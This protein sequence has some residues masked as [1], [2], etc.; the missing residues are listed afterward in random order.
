MS[1][2]GHV[3]R[4]FYHRL[5]GR[6]SVKDHVNRGLKAGR[7]LHLQEGV[8]LDYSH[9]WHIELGDDVTIAPRAIILAHDAS[10]RRSLGYTRLGKVKI[11]NRVFIGAGSIVLPGVTIGDDVIV[12]AGSVVSSDIQSG[13]VVVGNP[14]RVL[15]ST[16][17]YLEGKSKELELSPRFDERYTLRGGVTPAMKEDMNRA[18]KNRIGYVV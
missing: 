8:I 16:Q 7:N 14:A 11:G 6:H 1:L 5:L 15:R 17:E 2:I 13:V 18:M 10:T 3:L 9:I 4:R 12:G